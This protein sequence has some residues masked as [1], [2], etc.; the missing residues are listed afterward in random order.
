M[1]VFAVAAFLAGAYGCASQGPIS[2]AGDVPELRPGVLA[3]YLPADQRPDS[4]R[5][6]PPPPAPGSQALAADEEAA[7]ANLAK[8][9]TPRWQLAVE[10]AN[11]KFP[12]A[13]ETF[14]C[15]LG[16]PINE[17]DT[18]QLYLLLRRSLVDAGLS[19]YRA[20]EHYRRQRPFLVNHLPTCT[21][22]DVAKLAK[23][24]S[25]PSGHNAAG[26][27]WALI[28]TEVDP[29]RADAILARGL[30]Y[31]QSRLACNVHWQSDANQ[32]RIMGAATVAR[33]HADP[34]FRADL[35]AA[36]TEVAAARAKG[37]KPTRDCAAE[38]AALGQ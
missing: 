14:S 28:L 6:V 34:T 26:W 24:G 20:K 12:Q 25:Y 9:G 16:V 17:R 29:E 7:R 15:A 19:T 3:G 2:R 1:S 23:D 8:A 13:A 22:D 11:L 32:G 4:L 21:P 37:L 30:A 38:R 36:R 35:A 18:P 5:L 31:G 27:A 10:D 33:L